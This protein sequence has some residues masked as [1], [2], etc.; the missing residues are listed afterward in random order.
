MGVYFPKLVLI[1]RSLVWK[2]DRRTVFVHSQRDLLY[3]SLLLRHFHNDISV[4]DVW[5]ESQMLLILM[6]F[7]NKTF[8]IFRFYLRWSVSLV[9]QAMLTHGQHWIADTVCLFSGSTS[10]RVGIQTLQCSTFF[11]FLNFPH[12]SVFFLLIT[13][14]SIC[15]DNIYNILRLFFTFFSIQILQ[16]AMS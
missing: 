11:R 5:L 14:Q 3:N 15:A 9:K 8:F 1:F 16:Y 10:S 7:C 2:M 4:L 13:K 12:F 6:Y